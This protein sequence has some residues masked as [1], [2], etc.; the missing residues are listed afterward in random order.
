MGHVN[1][2]VLKIKASQVF[3]NSPQG[4]R[5]RGQPK[6]K[7][8]NLTLYKQT[9]KDSKLKIKREKSKNRSNWGKSIEEAQVRIG[10]KGD[11]RRRTARYRVHIVPSLV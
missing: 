11:V 8:H 5:L 4:S 2:R 3:N 10:L 1:R 6:K 9:L 7:T